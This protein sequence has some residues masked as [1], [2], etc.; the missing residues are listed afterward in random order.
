MTAQHKGCETGADDG[1][2]KVVRQ[3][4]MTAQHKGCETG[5]DDSTTQ[6]L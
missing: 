3:A 5:A 2:T 6:R 1:T 4:L